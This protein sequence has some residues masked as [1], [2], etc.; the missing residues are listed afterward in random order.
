MR[1]GTPL[2]PTAATTLGPLVSAFLGEEPPIAV[3]C[4]DGSVI[5]DQGAPATIAVSTPNAVR[6]LLWSPNELGLGRAYVAGE[7]DVHGDVFAALSLRD[8]M[9]ERDERLRI[10]LGWR[11]WLKA[12]RA[13]L[14]LHVIGRPLP[15]PAQEAK[16]G[17]RRH[18][19]NR[20][21]AAITHHYDLS[22]D[23]YRLVLGPSLTYSCA[24]FETAET[25]LEEAQANK[26]DV[27]ARKLGL[28]P[29]MRLLDV[30]CGWGSM[31]LHAAKHYGV[32]GVGVT[33]S[34]AQ[35]QL[36]TERVAAAG[37][38]GD[39]DIRVQDYRAI[40][41]GPF[42]AIS[43]IGMF[44][45]VGRKHLSTYFQQLFDLLA[46]EG[47][48]LNH[49]ISRPG[50]EESKFDKN[51]FIERYVFPDGELHEVG[52]VVSMMQDRG[53]EVRDVES[54]REHY[55]RTLRVW[56]AN[57]EANWEQA[58]DLVGPSARIW[59]LYMAGSALHFE[60][61][62]TSIHQVLAVKPGPVGDSGMPLSRRALLG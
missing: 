59:R 48:L 32:T 25:T 61:G 60:A 45:H 42:D 21:A 26:Y 13:A 43:S 20:D 22:N 28:K 51:G 50:G 15:P 7:L 47:R 3:Q 18:S 14:S 27:I 55:A 40:D 11:G 57:L 2:R 41:D 5:G 62:R 12:L 34:P 16:L 33:L 38:A 19:R 10:G 58:V 35:A 37:L 9:A 24:Y 56:V 30:G 8:A 31:L 1:P 44:E 17:G 54:L 53:F 52:T 6:R 4:W 39:I 49:G 23:F 29:G 46:P 36:A